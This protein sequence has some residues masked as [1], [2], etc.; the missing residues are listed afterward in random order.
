M[1]TSNVIYA[2]LSICCFFTSALGGL[3]EDMI[4]MVT[5]VNITQKASEQ[6]TL[7]VHAT[8][9]NDERWKVG[10]SLNCYHIAV[11]TIA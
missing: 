3:I 2:A 11:M 9:L 7:S 4:G 5:G 10:F 8:A 1:R 6:N